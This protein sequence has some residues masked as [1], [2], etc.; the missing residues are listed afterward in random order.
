[1]IGYF[2]VNLPM[3][4]SPSLPTLNAIDSAIRNHGRDVTMLQ[5][6]LVHRQLV[7][8]NGADLYA[9][10]RGQGPAVLFIAGATGDAGHFA[11]VADTLA[12]E[13][14]VVTYDRRGHS[15][16]PRPTGWTRTS[17][18]EQAD[19]A[20]G[21][22]AVLGLTPAVVFGTS[23]GAVILLNLLLRHSD[24]LRGAIVHEPPL[25]P[26]LANAATLGAELQAM[27][28]AALAAGGPRGAMET[29]LRL[30]AG[31]AAFDGLEP[32][33]RERMLDNGEVFFAAE[34]AA[35]VS[36]VPTA[37]EL[38]AVQTPVRVV[39][40]TESRGVY[41]YEA[42]QWVAASLGTALREIPGAHT[43]Y[44]SCPEAMVE[45][46]RPLLRDLVTATSAP[47][48]VGGGGRA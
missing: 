44:F 3:K 6:Q 31:D 10:I 30:N 12:D 27:V 22:L 16:S 24:R 15:R 17:I 41:Y 20:A 42:A 34:L 4:A 48:V 1:M 38:A 35:F 19:D 39:A 8:C 45:A 47:A 7:R 11:R 14:T 36:Y 21:L 13:F 29:F 28:E 25:V 46:L 26:V 18:A 23:G 40:G 2:L 9:E 5:T 33:L 37:G 32:A 43:P